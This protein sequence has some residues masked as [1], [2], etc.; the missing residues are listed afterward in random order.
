LAG[1]SIVFLSNLAPRTIRGVTSHGMVLAADL[2]GRPVLL[3]PPAEVPPGTFVPGRGAEDRTI[4]YEEFASY[5]LAVGT[6]GARISGGRT[7][8]QVGADSVGVDG[9]WT[10]GTQG[11]VVTRPPGAPTGGLIH[12]GSAGLVQLAEPVPEGAPVK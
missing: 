1:R 7:A 5:R 10:A 8:V 9:V 11:V 4:T 6:V 3:A 12:F 2:G